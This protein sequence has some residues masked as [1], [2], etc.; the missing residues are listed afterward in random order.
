MSEKCFDFQS[1]LPECYVFDS[2][3]P[4][5]YMF[6]SYLHEITEESNDP[7]DPNN[8]TIIDEE[9]EPGDIEVPGDENQKISCITRQGNALYLVITNGGL[10]TLARFPFISSGDYSI[11]SILPEYH[12][13]NVSSIYPTRLETYDVS[14]GGSNIA[15]FES[16]THKF[17]YYETVLLTNIAAVTFSNEF[18]NPFLSNDTCVRQ[19]S[20]NYHIKKSYPDNGG[21][22]YNDYT[23]AE[24]CTFT[25][26]CNDTGPLNEQVICTNVGSS[27]SSAYYAKERK[28]IDLS[29]LPFKYCE[30]YYNYEER[31]EEDRGCASDGEVLTGPKDAL[32]YLRD[33]YAVSN[34]HN[35]PIEF[36]FEDDMPS[37]FE[38]MSKWVTSDVWP[39][40]IDYTFHNSGN[41]GCTLGDK[42]IVTG[43]DGRLSG[44]NFARDNG[45]AISAHQ[46]WGKFVACTN[47]VIKTIDLPA[48]CKDFTLN[49]NMLYYVKNDNKVYWEPIVFDS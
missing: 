48:D 5:C 36:I 21:K 10:R 33:N 18:A 38:I 39:G 41:I 37:E 7:E 25:P 15:L 2:H 22:H 16:S 40:S 44:Q 12:S 28:I 35:M 43:A 24:G 26:N 32:L 20:D 11:S 30:A 23:K 29:V 45:I 46:E 14:S 27:T 4:E 49:G 19:G 8:P 17:Y 42:V 6:Y 34:N 13:I 1:H 9:P 31:K 3:L 47:G